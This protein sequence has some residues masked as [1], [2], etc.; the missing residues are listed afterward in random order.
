MVSVDYRISSFNSPLPPSLD[1]D[2]LL[3]T[4]GECRL[5]NFLLFQL[6]FA[7]M[8]FLEKYWPE[9]TAKDLDD[10]LDDFVRRDRRFGC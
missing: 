4:S 1:P 2:L 7:E 10:V 6:A 5:S 3:R 8:V 9:V